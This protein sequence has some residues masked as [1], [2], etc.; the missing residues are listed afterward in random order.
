MQT[1]H[2]SVLLNEVV[3]N[4]KNLKGTFIDCTLGYAGHSSAIL[5]TNPNLNLIACDRDIEAINFS[6]KRLE[7]F[8]DRVKIIKGNFSEILSKL[9]QTEKENIV[10]ILADIGVSSLQLDKN[11]RG[12]ALNSDSLDMRMDSTSKLSA[13]DVV[14]EY[15]QAKLEYI[16]K[17]YAE[18][19]SAKIL[20][21]KIVNARAI[22]PIKSAKELTNIIGKRSVNGRNVSEAILAFQAIRIEVNKEL[23]EL[24]TL[25]DCIKNSG[26]KNCIVAII[27]FHSLEDR[28]VKNTFKLWQS[29]CICPPQSARCVCGKNHAIGKILTK[30]PIIASQTELK[31]NPRSSSA[32]MRIFKIL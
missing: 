11:D 9:N 13:Y 3:E 22:K 16:F 18:L 28:I 2:I 20:A 23:D 21:N 32:K 30:K 6:T 7:F 15:T 31:A 8:K 14:N 24:T 5:K 10:A 26:I 17:E 12:F 19:T 4:F 27:S 25:L 1:P 29:D